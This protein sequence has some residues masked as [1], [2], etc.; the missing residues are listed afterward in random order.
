MR[1]ETP[2][3]EMKYIKGE[4]KATLLRFSKGEKID[5]DFE[6]KMNAVSVDAIE[7]LRLLQQSIDLQ[8][9]EIASLQTA[10]KRMNQDNARIN[11]IDLFAAKTR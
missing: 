3:E 1:Y 2:E 8:K 6:R 9:R 11:Q 4:L 7:L 5:I 10:I